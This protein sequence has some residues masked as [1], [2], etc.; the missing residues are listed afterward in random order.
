MK[1][2][3]RQIQEIHKSIREVHRELIALGVSGKLPKPDHDEMQL[4]RLIRLR[5]ALSESRLLRTEFLPLTPWASTNQLAVHTARIRA[6]DEVIID[7]IMDFNSDLRRGEKCVSLRRSDQSRPRKR[8]GAGGASRV[9][10]K[11]T[12]DAKK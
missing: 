4:R 10:Q 6:A 2:A 9:S 11:N 1:G 5:N 8:A 7:T 3:K 12:K